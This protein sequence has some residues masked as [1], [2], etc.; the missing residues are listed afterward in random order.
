MQDMQSKLDE[1]ST[2]WSASVSQVL[3]IIIFFLMVC[4]IFDPFI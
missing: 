2:A 3:F 4:S 1:T